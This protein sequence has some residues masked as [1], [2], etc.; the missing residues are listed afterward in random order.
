MSTLAQ[1]VIR[2][3][4]PYGE[5]PSLAHPNLLFDAA[6]LQTLR[7]RLND[8]DA[9]AVFASLKQQCDEWMDPANPDHPDWQ[10]L[11]DSRWRH[12][13]GMPFAMRP[14]EFC[15]FVYAVT[16]ERKYAEFARN[17]VFAVIRNGL[18]DHQSKL[19]W[20]AFHTV[21][22]YPGWRHNATHDFGNYAAILGMFYDCCCDLLTEEE[23]RLFVQHAVE[24]FEI[25]Q[26]LRAEI[27][28]MGL[29]NRGARCAMGNALLAMAVYDEAERRWTQYMIRLGLR[30][31]HAWASF[32]I[33]IDGGAFEGCSY[34]I[35]T[36]V[37]LTQLGKA[38]ARRGLRD[39]SKHP[40]FRGLADFLIYNLAPTHD[41]F[42][43]IND[44]FPDLATYGVLLMSTVHRDPVAKWLY[45]ELR[46][47]LVLRSWK[48]LATSP[49]DFQYIDRAVAPMSPS[50]A[51]Y[52][53]A[54]HFRDRG[55]VSALSS[56]DAD[57]MQIIFFS[58][59]QVYG[60]HRQDDQNS[61]T[62]CAL[63]DKFAWDAGYDEFAGCY[64]DRIYR[65]S[66]FH[67]TILIDGMGQVGY[68]TEFWPRGHI[69]AFEHNDQWTYTRGD[70][71]RCYGINGVIERADRHI[72]FHRGPVP[73]VIMVDDVIADEFEHDVTFNFVAHPHTK[74]NALSSGRFEVAGPKATLDICVTGGAEV[75]S[76]Q[77]MAG[78][79]PRLQATQHG[80]HI[81]F[82]TL[83]LPRAAGVEGYA[84]DVKFSDESVTA[85]VAIKPGNARTEVTFGRESVRVQ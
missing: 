16:G 20:E 11:K 60:G 1:T 62:F 68:D 39:L 65:R 22:E 77:D 43:P 74:L 35:T 61:F 34:S 63:G 72:Y 27:G 36:P 41:Q 33:G 9:A 84:F 40:N 10:T 38:A 57:A 67:N 54:R 4:L 26:T 50:E 69:S 15:S 73:F 28:R 48:S 55:V 58:G 70:A 79:M 78:N 2:K 13:S 66:E 14:V 7:D 5:L 25:V 64:K 32:A 24:C 8:P 85:S 37:M 23:R 59:P 46:Q 49:V 76:R 31:G 29:N 71:G 47:K 19:E 18:A 42:L 83:L 81:R 56:W 53:L 80:R 12:R 21:E 75:V 44:C 45:G 30:L 82:A 6:E 3:E 52:P 17:I 51:R